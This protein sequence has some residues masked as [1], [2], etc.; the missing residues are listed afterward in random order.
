VYRKV[1]SKY[2]KPYITYGLLTILLTKKSI[3]M[4]FRIRLKDT[5]TLLG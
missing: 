3:L 4:G 1:L 2:N 5:I